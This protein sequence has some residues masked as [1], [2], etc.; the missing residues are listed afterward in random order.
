[1]RYGMMCTLAAAVM[2][3][4]TARPAPAVDRGSTSTDFH[5]AVAASGYLGED[6]LPVQEV[7][8]RRGPGRGTYTRP[9]S[10]RDYRGPVYRS[11]Y[12]PDYRSPYYQRPYRSPYR[13]QY[14]YPY[15]YSPRGFYFRGP[16]VG[17]GIGW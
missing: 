10:R 5:L 13:Y 9:P 15:R 16:R 11:P 3:A 17:F 12:R 1:M 8:F 14:R 7:Q 2:V 6:G 4:A